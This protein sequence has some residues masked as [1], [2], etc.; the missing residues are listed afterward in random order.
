[1]FRLF[2]QREFSVE[3]V[4]CYNDLLVYLRETDIVVRRDLAESIIE[5]Y[6][7]D[8]S[9]LEVNTTVYVRKRL[10]EALKTICDEQEALMNDRSITA[11][12]EPN[13]GDELELKETHNNNIEDNPQA[14]KLK[15]QIE[16]VK[17]CADSISMNLLDILSRFTKTKDFMDSLEASAE[18]K[19]LYLAYKSIN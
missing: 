14:Q 12:Q 7:N 13:V 19:Q 18:F 17:S 8:N 16:I 15:E 2:A 3:N 6:L 4:L 10:R 1:M 9:A 5:L 11:E